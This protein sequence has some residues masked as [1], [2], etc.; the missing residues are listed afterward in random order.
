MLWVLTLA[1]GQHG[2]IDIAER[3]KLPFAT[4]RVAADHL[5]GAGLLAEC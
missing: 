3:T 4:I 2:L 1:D 5:C